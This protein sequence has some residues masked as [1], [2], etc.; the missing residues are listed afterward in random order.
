[1]KASMAI[2]SEILQKWGSVD[3]FTRILWGEGPLKLLLPTLASLLTADS[4]EFK[5]LETMKNNQRETVI[6]YSLPSSIA[7]H[8]P[9]PQDKEPYTPT[10]THP[11][12]Q[13]S[14]QTPVNQRTASGSSFG[15]HSTETT[16][17]K[18]V[19]AEPKVQAL[20]NEFVKCILNELWTSQI[21]LSWVK[22]RQMSLIYSEYRPHRFEA[23]PRTSPTSFQ[24]TVR[25]NEDEVLVGRV[26][27]IADG[28]LR[29]R[30][31]KR[32]NPD[33]F[34]YWSRQKSALSF[35]VLQFLISLIVG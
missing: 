34:C 32:T 33:A 31:N 15:T 3:G 6:H 4:Q 27:A 7:E 35:E 25:R 13:P 21:D 22:G 20:Q 9:S 11:R 28:C 23:H 24:Y 12:P 18:L 29:L 8:R 19:H 1:M 17:N 2:T 30:T 14:Y 16:P 26:K 10:R 5:T